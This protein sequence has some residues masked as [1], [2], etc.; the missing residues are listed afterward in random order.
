MM[1]GGQPGSR[2][3]LATGLP[4]YYGPILS[5]LWLAAVFNTFLQLAQEEL[6]TD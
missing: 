2:A 3:W 1:S 5:E 4:P 6:S